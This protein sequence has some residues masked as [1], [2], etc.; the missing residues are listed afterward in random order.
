MSRKEERWVLHVVQTW[1][2]KVINTA[3][4]WRL[5]GTRTKACEVIVDDA[6]PGQAETKFRPNVSCNP[7]KL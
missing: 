1:Y 4:E 6:A 7:A 5:L 3:P 2:D